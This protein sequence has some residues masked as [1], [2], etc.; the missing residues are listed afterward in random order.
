MAR[1]DLVRGKIKDNSRKTGWAAD[2]KAKR[3]EE[4]EERNARYK[5]LSFD[6]KMARN[7]IKVQKKLLA[8]KEQEDLRQTKQNKEVKNVSG[9][10][11]KGKQKGKA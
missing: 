10:N 4:A 2:R 11:R 9:E 3:R 7:S 1:S 8:K 6:E 5:A